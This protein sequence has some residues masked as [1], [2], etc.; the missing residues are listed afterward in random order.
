MILPGPVGVTDGDGLAV[1][2]AVGDAE[3]L[4]VTVLAGE[5]EG[6]SLVE[7]AA[8]AIMMTTSRITTKASDGI[9]RAFQ[10]DR[11]MIVLL[12]PFLGAVV[13]LP[14][15]GRSSTMSPPESG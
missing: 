1:S 11:L 14:P 12:A 13:P 7:A 15:V 6:S 2:V 9:A 8:A 10:V 4:S 3:G 5:G